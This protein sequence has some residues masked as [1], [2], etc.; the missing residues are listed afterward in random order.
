M[1]RILLA[2]CWVVLSCSAV[3]C[4]ESES[5]NSSEI[6]GVEEKVWV[7]SNEES[8]E[9]K[10]L[11]EK[12]RKEGTTNDDSKLEEEFANNKEAQKRVKEIYDEI[13][14]K[15]ALDGGVKAHSRD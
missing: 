10:E 3:S 6:K 12:M 1:K 8:K 13:A 11:L 14:R 4:F 5:K 9:M 15:N 2:C 7:P